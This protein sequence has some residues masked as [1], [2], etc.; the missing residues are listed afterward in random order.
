MTVFVVIAGGG[1][2]KRIFS[3]WIKAAAFRTG[4][5]AGDRWQIVEMEVL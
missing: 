5:R 2:I 3:D 4:N 1:R